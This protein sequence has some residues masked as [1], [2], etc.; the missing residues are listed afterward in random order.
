MNTIIRDYYPVFQMFQSL[1]DQLTAVLHD[2]DLAYTPG[3]TN[4]TLGALC[5]EN[6]EVEYAY[7]QSFKTF[8]LK[9]FTYR[10]T[11][12]G[13]ESSVAAL[14]AWYAELDRDLKATIEG[15]SDDDLA[16]RKIERGGFD[17]SPQL[18]LDTYKD[19]LLLFYGRVIVYLKALEKT[20]P[21]SWQWL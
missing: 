1:R 9:E 8:E 15:L 19:A 10:N 4:P 21:D 7:I 3:G 13:L 2:T 18:N 6:G 11:Q 5:R 20:L 12:P 16:N 14:T 17:P